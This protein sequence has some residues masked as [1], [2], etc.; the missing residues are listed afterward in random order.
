[1]DIIPQWY[2]F[3]AAFFMDLL[4]GD[5]EFLP[6]PVRVM[7][8]AISF[9]E[10]KFRKLPVNL[11]FSGGLFALFLILS[12]W[13]LTFLIISTALP[14]V[15]VIKT[16]V[17]IV[18]IYY[19]LSARCLYTAAKKVAIPLSCGR[20]EI[21]RANLAMIVGRDVN[22][23]SKSGI[24]RA[25]IETVAE[26]LVDGFITPLF[27]AAIGGA[28]LALTYKM[29]NTL[30]S[31][32]GYKNPKYINFGKVAAKMDDAVNFIPARVSA[33]VISLAVK[34]VSDKALFVFKTA[35][36]QGRNHSS[37]NAGFPEAAFAG[38]LKIWLGGPSYYHKTIVNKPYIG[39]NFNNAVIKDIDKACQLMLFSATVWVIIICFFIFV[40]D[41]L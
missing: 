18:L 39:K 34:I 15:P 6:H 19:C 33:A 41:L 16:V 13:G 5:P 24:I 8:N 29:V 10:K 35:I 23:L 28:P 4:L 22:T 12:T 37:P 1:M 17:E 14:A 32:V 30:D 2:V 7:G 27:Y 9:F 20:T 11:T 26:N 31:M 38:A 40:K 25:T 3:A 21:A 36:S